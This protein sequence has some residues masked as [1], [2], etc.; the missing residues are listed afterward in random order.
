[1]AKASW[2]SKRTRVKS[3]QKTKL[4]GSNSPDYLIG[5]KNNNKLLGGHGS[6]ILD[7]KDGDDTLTGGAGADYFIISKGNTV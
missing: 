7:G 5:S 3:G 4:R 6:D 1:M 2:Q